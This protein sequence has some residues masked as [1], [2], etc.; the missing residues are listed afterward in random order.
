LSSDG[1]VGLSPV[2]QCR[3][4]LGLSSQLVEHAARFFEADA[5]PSGV[6]KV[7]QGP[8]VQ[9]QIDQLR[10]AWEAR[11]AGLTQS[12]RI[13]VLAGDVDFQAISMPLEDAQ[14]LQQRQLS[15]QEVARIFRCPP[16]AIGAPTGD[17]MTYATTEQ[18]SL[19][20]VTYSLRPHL[21]ADR[22]SAERRSIIAHSDLAG[23]ARR[24]TGGSIPNGWVEA[25][26]AALGWTRAI[27][28]GRAQPGREGRKEPHA[29]LVTY[30]GFLIDADGAVT[31]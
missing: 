20:F 26:I 19:A 22:A 3:V 17:P 24:Y 15:A 14:F 9:D 31:T 1:I 28:E 8:L 18:S 11:H 21:I 29:R 4:A 5:R 30:R 7:P 13:A 16:W 10:K 12:H 23:A 27:L 6:L 2:R 25:R